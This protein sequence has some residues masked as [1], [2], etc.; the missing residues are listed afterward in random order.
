MGET[1][2]KKMVSRS[3]AVALG[4]ICIILV[5]GLGVVLF[6][7]FS[8]TSGS[9]QTTYNDYVNDHHH[10]D[11]E[12]NSL[13]NQVNDLTNTLNLGKSLWPRNARPAQETGRGARNQPSS[14]A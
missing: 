12:Y 7:G 8:P 2:P 11:E 14:I 3:V 5:A 10:T 1:N 9:L 6:I 4:I 13:Q